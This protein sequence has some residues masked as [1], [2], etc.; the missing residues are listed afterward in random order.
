MSPAG[1]DNCRSIALDLAIELR[2]APTVQAYLKT[3][4]KFTFSDY[5]EFLMLYHVTR[6]TN[7]KKLPPELIA[8]IGAVGYNISVERF[9]KIDKLV[10]E[11][12][13]QAK[14]ILID[15]PK[16]KN[17]K[18]MNVVKE[19]WPRANEL[20][21]TKEKVAE[22]KTDKAK[23]VYVHMLLKRFGHSLVGME[24]VLTILDTM[25]TLHP[26]PDSWFW[27]QAKSVEEQ[28]NLTRNTEFMHIKTKAA[29]CETDEEKKVTDEE[30]SVY[31][32]VLLNRFSDSLKGQELALEIL[33]AM[34]TLHPKSG[35]ESR[36]FAS[37]HLQE[38]S[39]PTLEEQRAR[40]TRNIASL[41]DEE[42]EEVISTTTQT[43]PSLGDLCAEKLQLS[44]SPD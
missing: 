12:I 20:L 42:S 28:K 38:I 33:N 43:S 1:K 14:N 11:D 23:S 19:N 29:Q 35:G 13:Y 6:G 18:W 22:C 30:K 31:V 3:P 44:I 5:K 26:G 7:L 41:K 27:T 25:K 4:K 8:L 21:L 40:V 2:R 16:D 9:S 37:S 34:K 10:I 32:R 36:L 24:T 15:N 17:T 39:Q